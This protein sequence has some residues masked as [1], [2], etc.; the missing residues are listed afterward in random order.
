MAIVPHSGK[1]HMRINPDILS[2]IKGDNRGAMRLKAKYTQ[3][4]NTYSVPVVFFEHELSRIDTNYTN[5]QPQQCTILTI[6]NQRNY[7]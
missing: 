1:Q 6:Q 2:Y 3:V 7:D 5:K 4:D